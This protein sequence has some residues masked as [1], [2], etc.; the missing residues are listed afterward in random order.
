[1]PRNRTQ[2]ALQDAYNLGASVNRMRLNGL[3]SNNAGLFGRSARGLYDLFKKR[4]GGII[5]KKGQYHY[6]AGGGPP[7]SQAAFDKMTLK[8]KQL[9]YQ[10]N[11]RK[12]PNR[13]K[14]RRGTRKRGGKTY[15]ARKAPSSAKLMN[16][17]FK[18]ARANGV[19]V[20]T[21]NTSSATITHVEIVDVI[22]GNGQGAS[23]P[24]IYIFKLNPGLGTIFRWGGP[25]MSN[26]M[27][28][29][30]LQL[31]IRLTSTC[32]STTT[33]RWAAG[34]DYNPYYPTNTITNVNL[35]TTLHSVMGDVKDHLSL[36][37]QMNFLP[38]PSAKLQVRTGNVP[39]GLDTM[40]YDM[41]N[42]YIGVETASSE[43]IGQF[44]VAYSFA[45]SDAVPVSEP[46]C[47]Y[48]TTGTID[49]TIFPSCF[50][51]A[52][53]KANDSPVVY[54]KS[55][56]TI[57][58]TEDVTTWDMRFVENFRGNL[59]VLYQASTD[60]VTPGHDF[61]DPNS[62]S[63]LGLPLICQ[64]TIDETASA[65]NLDWYTAFN[66]NWVCYHITLKTFAGDVLSFYT[67]N[68]N[69]T[70]TSVLFQLSDNSVSPL[71]PNSDPS[72]IQ[73][74]CMRPKTRTNIPL[75]I[76]LGNGETDDDDD[77]ACDTGAEEDI[78]QILPAL[79]PNKHN[80]NKNKKV[81]FS[82][83]KP[84]ARP[85]QV[86]SSKE[87]AIEH[88]AEQGPL[89]LC[90]LLTLLVVLVFGQIRPPTPRP[91]GRPTTR[92][93]T[94][95]SPTF[96]PTQNG[97]HCAKQPGT[98][99]SNLVLSLNKTAKLYDVT[100]MLKVQQLLTKF[101][102]THMQFNDEYTGI[103][104]FLMISTKCV[105]GKQLQPRI[106]MHTNNSLARITLGYSLL[107]RNYDVQTGWFY[108]CGVNKYDLLRFEW[109]TNT[110][111][112]NTITC[113]FLFAQGLF[114]ISDA[115]SNALPYNSTDYANSCSCRTSDCATFSDAPTASPIG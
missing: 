40:Q 6:V 10:A 74:G 55:T 111:N 68:A 54:S 113:T 1:M 46:H 19:S 60:S 17:T 110:T 115:L 61:G 45:M 87:M 85:G 73:Y 56:K 58:D 31:I 94:V 66:D 52:T 65:F 28:Y 27:Y 98:W 70:Y 59:L 67:Q 62:L 53:E 21:L 15:G 51:N 43:V 92:R 105:I 106:M 34:F 11:N 20:N 69:A 114:Q 86:K 42:L 91:I 37:M 57:Q 104:S 26:W 35:I 33:G 12:R 112:G 25:V 14:P 93:P 107:S 22:V 83:N 3:N 78:E 36:T 109:N 44:S 108:V 2:G 39:A 90:L 81:S 4:K 38:M 84:V 9:Q 101:N 75:A 48:F 102:I 89:S 77:D 18:A 76:T 47:S 23:T 50:S 24:A 97:E 100:D 5:Q 29:L 7:N 99:N 88:E 16:M 72:N 103:V 30:P 80:N 49:P 13:G 71:A 79:V 41:G 95:A 8:Q 32:A 82:V 64:M 96:R 63:D